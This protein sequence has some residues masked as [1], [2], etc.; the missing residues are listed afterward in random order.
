MRAKIRIIELD[1]HGG[2]FAIGNA[3]VEMFRA[4][5]LA[6]EAAAAEIEPEE[7]AAG[8]DDGD[9]G[10]SEDDEGD[11]IEAIRAEEDET[12]E[13]EARK[14]EEL[15]A[16]DETPIQPANKWAL[17][18]FT[19]AARREVARLRT[20]EGKSY[21]QIEAMDFPCEDGSMRQASHSMISGS[22]KKYGEEFAKPA[23]I[24]ATPELKSV[25]V[26]GMEALGVAVLQVVREHGVDATI[27][28]A[29]GG[30]MYNNTVKAFQRMN[31]NYFFN[32]RKWPE[33]FDAYIVTDGSAV[34]AGHPVMTVGELLDRWP[35]CPFARAA[36]ATAMAENFPAAEVKEAGE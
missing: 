6:A 7:E 3:L 15:E 13:F 16:A 36:A 11:D 28:T 20:V 9:D 24:G 35:D 34:Q 14:N 33:G 25:C 5:G 23:P 27:C 1:L 4:G 26:I 31:A 22:V 17:S 12:R 30:S 8:D 18:P 29:Q 21:S 19:D 10:N 32:V 2:E